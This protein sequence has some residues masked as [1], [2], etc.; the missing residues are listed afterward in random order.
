MSEKKHITIGGVNPDLWQKWR[1]LVVLHKQTTG[2]RLNWLLECDLK[3]QETTW[4][5]VQGR[6]GE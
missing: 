5:K 1:A 4:A 6:E 3:S 2:D